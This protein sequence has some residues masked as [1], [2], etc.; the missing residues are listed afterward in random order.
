MKEDQTPGVRN[1][2]D[3]EYEARRKHSAEGAE[4]ESQGQARSAA[5]R[6]ARGKRNQVRPAALKGRNTYF[7]PSGLVLA[8]FCNQGR[9]ASLRC[10]LAPGFHIPRLWRCRSLSFRA[11]TSQSFSL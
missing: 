7:G 5:Q 1:A 10:A 4:Y 11:G 9:R 8:L 6:V 2:E 3:A